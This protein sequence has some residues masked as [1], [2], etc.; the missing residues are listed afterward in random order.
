M[1]TKNGALAV[2]FEAILKSTITAKSF[3]G[4]SSDIS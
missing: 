4:T 3:L 1:K 2:T